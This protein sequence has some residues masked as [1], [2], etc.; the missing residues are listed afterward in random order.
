MIQGIFNF[1]VALTVVFILYVMIDYINNSANKID[2]MNKQLQ[3]INQ[4][5]FSDNI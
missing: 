4:F 5:L 1:I 2:E 3:V